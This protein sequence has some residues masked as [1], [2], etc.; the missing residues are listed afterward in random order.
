MKLHQEEKKEAF[1]KLGAE[2]L[3]IEGEVF[4]ISN[5]TMEIVMKYGVDRKA[6]MDNFGKSVD[7]LLEQLKEK[8]DKL[9]ISVKNEIEKLGK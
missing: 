4:P 8:N 2:V 7:T 9:K 5:K 1:I 3:S 6:L